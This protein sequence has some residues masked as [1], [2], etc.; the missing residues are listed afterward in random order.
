MT[1]KP[2]KLNKSWGRGRMQE[3]SEE[4]LRAALGFDV[5]AAAQ[6]WGVCPWAG[7]C[8]GVKPLSVTRTTF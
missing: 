7:Q 2:L 8:S 1:L 3:K 5:S 6:T 4:G